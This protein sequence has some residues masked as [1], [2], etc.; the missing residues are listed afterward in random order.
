MQEACLEITRK[1]AGPDAALAVFEGEGVALIHTP[2]KAFFARFVNGALMDHEG[3]PVNLAR[4]FE[5]R[6]FNEEAELRWRRRGE[7]GE[8]ALLKEG[9]G[10]KP[11]WRRETQYLLWGR[12]ESSP[13]DR[14]W[15]TLFSRQ[16]KMLHA[17][18]DAE[19][20]PAQKIRENEYI[21][22]KAYEYFHQSEGGDGNVVFL[23]ERLSHLFIH[24]PQ[25]RLCMAGREKD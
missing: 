7:L 24:V 25:K 5:F 16:T 1:E 13:T 20:S 14:G 11:C 21:A 19:K 3:Q 18:Y 12:P 17:P 22:M 8:M 9:E 2:Q 10:G 23:A 15:V 4:A 6:L